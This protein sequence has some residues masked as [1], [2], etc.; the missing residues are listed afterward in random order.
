MALSGLPPVRAG[1]FFVRGVQSVRRRALNM[2]TLIALGTGTAWLYSVAMTI[3]GGAVYFESAAM[4]IVLTLLG[5]VLELRARD[6]TSGAIRGLR[7]KKLCVPLGES[8]ASLG[9]MMQ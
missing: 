9:S 3:T 8:Q 1:R 4:I 2:F 7:R 5:Q 6:A